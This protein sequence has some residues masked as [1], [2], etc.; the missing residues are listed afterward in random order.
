VSGRGLLV[1]L[2]GPSGVGKNTVLDRL[3][4][5]KGYARAVTATTRAPRPGEVDGVDYV[6]LTEEQFAARVAAKEFLEH[7]TVHGRSYGTPHRHVTEILDRGEVCFLA[8]DVQGAATLRGRV[9]PALSVFLLPPSLAVLEA[10]LR[11]RRTE[12]EAALERRLA[13]A[14]WE[15]T[16]EDEYDI[17]VVNADLDLAVEEIRAAIERQRGTL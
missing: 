6:F 15:L 4:E 8:V 3:L 14:R 17:S 12:D 13:T 16:R 1:V 5:T 2:S 7:A 9:E 11:G 10:R